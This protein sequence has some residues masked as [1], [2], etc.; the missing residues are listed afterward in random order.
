[1]ATYSSPIVP[2][3]R[4]P[5]LEQGDRLARSEFLRRYVVM[6]PKIKAE[7]IE[8]IVHI[9][10]A[11]VLAQFH[12]E[13]HAIVLTWLGVYQSVTPGVAAADNSTVALDIDND[14]QPD[15]CLRILPTYGGATKLNDEGYIEG[16]P[17]LIVE[18][19]ASTLSFDLGA[20]LNAYRRNGVREYIV[21]RTYDGDLDWF[22]LRDGQYQRLSPDNQGIYRSH[23]FPGL[24]LKFDA[25]MA[26]R[27]AEVLAVLQHGTASPE[28]GAFCEVLNPNA[29]AAAH[30]SRVQLGTVQAAEHPLCRRAQDR[31]RPS[32]HPRSICERSEGSCATTSASGPLSGVTGNQIECNFGKR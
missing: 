5:P 6:P 20:K 30:E 13:H 16:A 27:I 4:V 23:V 31:A 21:L 14:A 26:G 24:W 3:L 28:H 32:G 25:L 1:M 7:R 18:V 2:S 15:A 19:A 9:P 8:G 17:E 12:G 22:V 29:L 11:A 10:A